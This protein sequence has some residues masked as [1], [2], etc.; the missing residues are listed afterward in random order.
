MGLASLGWAVAT[1][2][3]MRRCAAGWLL[4][5]N[6]TISPSDRGRRRRHGLGAA[7]RG[8]SMRLTAPLRIG[9]RQCEAVRA[10]RHPVSGDGAGGPDRARRHPGAGGAVDRAHQRE[11][12]RIVRQKDPLGLS[13]H[14]AAS[15]LPNTANI[16]TELK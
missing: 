10:R 8:T 14:D 2:S 6:T 4:I 15:T 11:A 9:G 16:G 12:D 7:D 13:E 5:R 3:R 1:L